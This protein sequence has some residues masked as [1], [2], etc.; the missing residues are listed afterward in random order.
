MNVVCV[1]IH[2]S[3]GKML[4]RKEQLMRRKK[5]TSLAHRL[6]ALGAEGFSLGMRYANGH[7]PVCPVQLFLLLI[8][9]NG[10]KEKKMKL[11]SK[12][13]RQSWRAI[14]MHLTSI[15]DALA[16]KSKLKKNTIGV[17]G[18]Q[19]PTHSPCQSTVWFCR[20]SWETAISRRGGNGHASKIQ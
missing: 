4:H 2:L 15:N 6:M 19:T 14:D 1:Y 12:T 11:N 20:M 16:L 9:T 8:E 17:G 10:N 3:V 5:S 7:Q 13:Q 18:V